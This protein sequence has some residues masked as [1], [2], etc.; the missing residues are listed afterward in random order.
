MS[1]L[2]NPHIIT[3][4]ISG[5]L[6]GVLVLFS[7]GH[8]ILHK[9]DV[10]AA[11]GWVGIICL[12]PLIGSI[13]Y[14]LFGI[15]RVR[16]KA[17]KQRAII[18]KFTDDDNLFPCNLEKLREQILP[19]QHYLMQ[20]VKVT[21][22]ISRHALVCGND[23]TPFMTGEDAYRSM[24][25]S[26]GEAQQSISLSTYIFKNDQTGKLFTNALVNAVKR[27]VEVRV[28]ID[29][30]GSRYSF[31]PIL[32]TLR[33]LHIKVKTF[34]PTFALWWA[35]Y[36]HLRNHRKLLIVDGRIGFT[37]GMN[38]QGGH[39]LKGKEKHAIE[40]VHFKI[41]GPVVRHLQKTFI[42]D[43]MYAAKEELQGEKWLPKIPSQGD[44]IARG[45]VDGPD[46]A[47][48]KLENILL[49]ALS[50]AQKSVKIV[51]PYFLP[52]TQLIVALDTAAMRGIS[53][54]I[55]I[56][57]KNNQKL[58]QWASMAQLRYV[59][60]RGC[61]VWLNPSPFDHSKFIIVD[62]A[63]VLFGSSNWDPR[64]FRLNFEFN[65]ESYSL[66][67][68]ERM[69]KLF[70]AKKARAFELTMKYLEKRPLIIKLRD[71]VA[72]LF[73]PYL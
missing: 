56:P 38:I 1:Y 34:M 71:G 26:I 49:A 29:D 55:I 64:S 62:D 13:L 73:A 68:A 60:E 18:N 7:A 17:I 32:H 21:D 54:D 47:P 46:E 72:R 20:L 39:M 69:S 67:L 22:Q 66:I 43:W 9:R 37:G 52:E 63:W 30:V 57:Q 31:P 27:G 44:I 2:E 33:K 48:R 23:I 5:L 51:T 10:R 36:L 45:I 35:P 3:A 61:K 25:G 16:R 15:N 70:D 50:C 19:E 42:E 40:D 65:I 24:L 58:V 41:R 11:I 12:L 53:V 8:A 4:H 28:L 59:I 14:V 6:V